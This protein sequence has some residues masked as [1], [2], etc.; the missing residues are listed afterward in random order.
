LHSPAVAAVVLLPLEA[1]ALTD[2]TAVQAAQ[3]QQAK[4]PDRQ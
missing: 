4:L 1:T 2:Q 3:E